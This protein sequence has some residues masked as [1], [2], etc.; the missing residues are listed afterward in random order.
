M[1]TCVVFN[2]PKSCN[3]C[4]LE[5][6]D[7]RYCESHCRLYRKDNLGYD[8]DKEVSSYRT[9]RPEWCPLRPMKTSKYTIE[10]QDV[11]RVRC[12]PRIYR[13]EV[14]DIRTESFHTEVRFIENFTRDK[15]QGLR[16]CVVVCVHIEYFRDANDLLDERGI[17]VYQ[18][19]NRNTFHALRKKYIDK[20]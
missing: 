18:V 5:D 10:M 14:K 9:K 2:M 12:L 15:Q 13:T 11:E 4:Y 17:I 3:E 7:E 19:G 16:D 6:Y 8:D 1:K 20:R